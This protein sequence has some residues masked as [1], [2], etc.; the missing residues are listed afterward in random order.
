MRTERKTAADTTCTLERRNKDYVNNYK[1]EKKS[2]T[3]L[4]EKW[5][6]RHNGSGQ[7]IMNFTVLREEISVTLQSRKIVRN[8][9]CRLRNVICNTQEP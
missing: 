4:Q 2:K 5:T 7:M 6:K 8:A 3:C 1:M 9:R